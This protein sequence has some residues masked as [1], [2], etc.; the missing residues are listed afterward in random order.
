M[1]KLL[2][3]T[4]SLFFIALSLH[5]Q[6]VYELSFSFPQTNEPIA[7]KACYIDAE[8]DTGKIRL[9]FISPKGPDSILVDM[10][11]IQEYPDIKSDCFVS[12]RIYYK[13]QN[14]KYIE[15][16]D[17]AVSLPKYLCFKKDPASGLFEPFGITNS[18]ADC[19]AD[20]V[21]F[22]K[23]AFIEH[24]DLTKEFVLTYFKPY[25][26]F[27]RNL[28]V[29]NNTKALTT[30]EQNIKLYLLVVANV[31]DKKIGQADRKNM[32]DAIAFFRKI[33]EFLGI[34]QFIY[35]TIANMK[36]YNKKNVADKINTFF[37][38]APD[39]IVVFY[40]SG[41]G[42]R[43]PK[44]G[45]PGPYIDMRTDYS[46][47]FMVNSLSMED[48]MAT[49]QKKGARLNLVLSDCC[50]AF[51]NDTNP[52]VEPPAT[53]KSFGVNW[54]TQNCRN[55]FLNKMPTSILATAASP[56]QLAAMNN[57]FG[58][59]FSHF[60]RTALETHFSFLKTKVTWEQVFEQT[61]IQTKHKADYTW[62]DKVT[63]RKCNQKPFVCI[64]YGRSPYIPCMGGF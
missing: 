24:K 21:R 8:D 49:I 50:N 56:Y 9:R 48:I 22:N 11:V 33:K 31:F 63:K 30:T 6:T 46:K 1:K 40:Y 28:F 38:P 4:F 20:V 64:N 15:S 34:D 19:K 5:A 60:F 52:M 35:D 37:K 42:F 27:Y 16:K 43:K 51:V 7:Y 17:P 26:M 59:F 23:V 3:F 54:S 55:L 18:S 53:K 39:D 36:D 32:N 45:K 47:D 13:L 10:D 62:C 58:G 61:K 41:H 29:T 2:V 57:E 12:D 44:D 14:A 25:D